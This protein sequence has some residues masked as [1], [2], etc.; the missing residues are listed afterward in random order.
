VP[1]LP[2]VESL[3]RSLE[4][5][6]RGARVRHARVFRDDVLHRGEGAATVPLAAGCRLEGF[7]R[8]G[9]Q[10]LVEGSDG[11]LLVHLGMSGS[12]RI[13]DGE[14][15][16]GDE[17]HVH[18]AWTLVCE[19]G[20]VR[21]LRHRDPRRFGWLESHRDLDAARSACWRGLGPD[22]LEI[23]AVRLGVALAGSR[24]AIKAA[25]LDQSVTAGIGN[26]YAD[27]SLF[28]ARIHP[29]TPARR[30]GASDLQRLVRAIRTVLAKAVELG[31]STIQDHRTADGGWGS[32]QRLHRVYGRGGR[33]CTICRSE[34]RRTLVQQRATVFCPT[35][36]RRTGSR[37]TAR[38]GREAVRR[39]TT[40]SGRT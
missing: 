8:L 12:L 15:S 3:R 1:E 19:D 10:L 29:L 36:Q 18:A 28:R 35:C 33:P 7:H 38:G 20:I 11:C 30:L 5:R 22:A 27:E 23:D 31:G 4:R 40:S 6:L 25:L 32:F 9:K 2:E 26:I 34:L 24:R 17:S 13:V 16:V 39:L 21:T 37:Q 14:G